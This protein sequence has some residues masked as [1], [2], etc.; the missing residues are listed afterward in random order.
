MY[1][2]SLLAKCVNYLEQLGPSCSKSTTLKHHYDQLPAIRERYEGALLAGDAAG[3]GRALDEALNLGIGLQAAYMD[4]VARTQVAIGDR[5][6][7]GDIGVAQEHM[8]TQ[9][10][11]GQMEQ[12]RSRAT[13]RHRLGLRAVVTAVEGEEHLVGPRLVSD[14]LYLDGWDVDFLGVN[15]PAE[16]LVQFLAGRDAD[17]VGLSVTLADNLPRLA[18]SID[19]IRGLSPR[20]PILVGG[21][22]FRSDPAPRGAERADAVAVDAMDAV[23]K[24]RALVGLPTTGPTLDQLLDELGRRIQEARKRW[25]WSQVELARHAGLDRAYISGIENGKQNAT[26]GAVLKLAQALEVPLE[27]LVA[28]TS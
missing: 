11:L 8:A 13:T 5:W 12:L 9:V 18:R 21:A 24:A 3:A 14:L 15:T 6:L 25:G 28:A 23:R 26:L 1:I 22:I 17:L 7:A 27:D 4:I 10:A 20:P 19:L 16:S 2:Y